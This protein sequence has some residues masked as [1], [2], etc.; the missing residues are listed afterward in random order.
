APRRRASAA[1]EGLGARG[2]VLLPPNGEAVKAPAPKLQRRGIEAV[3][4]GFMHP[5]LDP[6]HERRTREILSH[7]LPGLAIS[8]SSEVSPEIREY[9]R[10]STAVANAYVQPAMS[11]YL[12]GLDAQLRARGGLCPLFLMT[13][14]GG[15]M[16]LETARKFPIRLVE[17]GPPGAAV[18]AA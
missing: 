9:E 14:S 13:S 17:S 7:L 16:T 12:G 5:Y 10:W 4:I 11:R 6:R 18:L 3:A 1:P 15:L 2:G 8:L